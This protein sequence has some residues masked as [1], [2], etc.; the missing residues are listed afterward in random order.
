MT[1]PD[2]GG[3]L[4]WPWEDSMLC[5]GASFYKV[6][7]P[8]ELR[9]GGRQRA[10]L[11]A[12][13]EGRRP[14]PSLNYGGC[15]SQIQLLTRCIIITANSPLKRNYHQYDISRQCGEMKKEKCLFSHCSLN[16]DKRR[17]GTEHPG[18]TYH[19]LEPGQVGH[20]GRGVGLPQAPNLLILWPPFGA[21]GG[22]P[23]V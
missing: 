21:P 1:R 15:W 17:R 8:Q 7:G 19:C 12:G 9:A 2:P 6:M 10:E 4:G 16:G 13:W 22:H 5:S 14:C 11:V 18:L 23:E 3:T 20:A